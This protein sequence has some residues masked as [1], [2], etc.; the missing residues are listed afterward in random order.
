MT[1]ERSPLHRHSQRVLSMV[2]HLHARGYQ[3]LRIWPGM[4]P[5]GTYWRCTV[6]V[7]SNLTGSNQTDLVDFDRLAL[8][9]SSASGNEYFDWADLT[10][11]S[12]RTLADALVEREPDLAAASRQRDWD[13]AGWFSEVLGHAERGWFPIFFADW[14]L[15]DDVVSFVSPDGGGDAPVM[16]FP[17]A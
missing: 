3:G 10:K 2:S 5:S 8:H 4:S 6:T 12:A 7:K 9:Y 17:P 11:P 15:P 13:Y 1:S 14:E 16:P